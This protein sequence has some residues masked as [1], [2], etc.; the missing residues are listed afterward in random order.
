[1]RAIALLVNPV[2]P[3]VDLIWGAFGSAMSILLKVEFG[4]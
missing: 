2:R 1:M 3:S 4:Q